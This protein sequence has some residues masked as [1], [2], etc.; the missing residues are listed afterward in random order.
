MINYV[1]AKIDMHQNSMYMLCIDRDETINQ[2]IS[3]YSKGSIRL[4]TIG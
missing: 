3:K 1:K 4:D 2:I